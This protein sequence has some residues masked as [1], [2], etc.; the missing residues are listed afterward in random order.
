M[1]ILKDGSILRPMRG[2][3]SFDTFPLHPNNLNEW[4]DFH[5][6]IQGKIKCS[7]LLQ[8]I[9]QNNDTSDASDEFFRP[10]C[11]QEKSQ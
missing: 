10:F 1:P 2:V 7:I 4:P 3:Q 8:R 11:K 9:E 6:T 5:V